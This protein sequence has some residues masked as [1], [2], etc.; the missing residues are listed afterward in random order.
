MLLEVLVVSVCA[1]GQPGCDRATQAY[2]QSSTE[3]QE[4][5]H[6]TERIGKRLVEGHEY[7]VYIATPIY[8]A[9]SGKDVVVK[10]K[11]DLNLNLNFKEESLALQWS[12]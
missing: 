11:K 3:V 6:N 12:Y 8:A 4:I 5:V 2:Y 1:S 10:I 9:I 7:L